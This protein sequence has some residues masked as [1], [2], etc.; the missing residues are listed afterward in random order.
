MPQ[1]PCPG[2][3]KLKNPGLKS[4]VSATSRIKSVMVFKEVRNPTTGVE[5]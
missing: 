5:S 1:L 4:D 3:H 2:V